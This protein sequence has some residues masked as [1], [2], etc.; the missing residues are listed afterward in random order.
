MI[1]N[2]K[3]KS[4]NSHGSIITYNNYRKYLI[5]YFFKYINGSDYIIFYT[6]NLGVKQIK[7]DNN[8]KT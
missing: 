7:Y 2:N 1:Y 5:S 6:R 3:I 4:L 8:T